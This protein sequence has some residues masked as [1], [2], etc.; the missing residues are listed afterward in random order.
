MPSYAHNLQKLVI[1]KKA[2][3]ASFVFL[4]RWN[5]AAGSTA[6]PEIGTVSEYNHAS[7]VSGVGTIVIP[8]DGGATALLPIYS[9]N[10]VWAADLF[11]VG[12]GPPIVLVANRVD[13]GVY[14]NQARTPSGS[15]TDLPVLAPGLH[16]IA[17]G[18]QDARAYVYVDGNLLAE[19]ISA[20]ASTPGYIWLYGAGVWSTASYP[21]EWEDVSITINKIYTGAT[22]QVPSLPL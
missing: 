9:L 17:I 8:E 2:I 6:V 20:P 1:Q 15:V 4:S 18:Q 16:H 14:R 11:F 13:F 7:G 19:S 12:E 22:I 21:C 3:N 10:T 5:G